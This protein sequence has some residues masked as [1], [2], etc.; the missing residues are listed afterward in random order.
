MQYRQKLYHDKSARSLKQLTP[1][2][3]VYVQKT[4]DGPWSQAVVLSHAGQPRSYRVRTNEGSVL[5]RNRKHLTARPHQS[6]QGLS[7]VSETSDEAAPPTTETS[8]ES[9]PSASQTDLFMSP[10]PLRD[11]QQASPSPNETTTV[12]QPQGTSETPL[13]LRTRYGRIVRGPLKLNL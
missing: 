4:P 11:G 5:R 2:D 9:P 6:Q 12:S 13:Q 1:G 3:A 10:L 8:I 7:R